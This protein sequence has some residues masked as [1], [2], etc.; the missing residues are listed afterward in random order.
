MESFKSKRA[1]H[2][3]F[4]FDHMMTEIAL[5]TVEEDLRTSREHI[6]FMIRNKLEEVQHNSKYGMRRI[7][8]PFEL[9]MEWGEFCQA[10]EKEVALKNYVDMV[11]IMEDYKH[12]TKQYH[13]ANKQLRRQY[14]T[15]VNKYIQKYNEAED[16]LAVIRKQ[17][18]KLEEEIDKIRTV[19]MQ[20]KAEHKDYEWYVQEIEK[21]IYPKTRLEVTACSPS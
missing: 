18:E 5:E 15:D 17:G 2:L 19:N 13:E 9:E 1:L 14:N 12:S 16:K 21:V 4:T 7:S 20:R 6:E 10:E 8:L 11:T 3:K